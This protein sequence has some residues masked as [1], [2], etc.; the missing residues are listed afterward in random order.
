MHTHR[1]SF[2]SSS[3][4]RRGFL[5]GSV[6][7]GAALLSE[8]AIAQARLEAA[9]AGIRAHDW[10]TLPLHDG[11]T[12]TVGEKELGGDFQL[13][14]GVRGDFEPSRTLE[15]AVFQSAG[16]FNMVGMH[17]VADVPEGTSL[18]V[19]VRGSR[20]GVKWGP[21][22]PVGHVMGARG[23]EELPE[24]AETF[25]DAVEFGRARAMQYRLT[26]GT[27][28]P[29]LSPIVR[30]VTAT[31]IDSLDAPTLEMLDENGPGIPFRVG[32][33]GAPGARLIP[34][35]G[36]TGWG[37]T[38]Y[39]P[40]SPLWWEPYT[41]VYPTQFV[42][43]HHTAWANNPENP[44]ATMRAV[45]YYHCVTLGWG[46]IGYHFLV[47]Q[48]GNIYQGRDGGH[49]TEAGHVSRYNHYNIGIC[50]M[51]QFHP[52]APDVPPGGEPTP[53]ALDTAM[54]MAALEAAWWGLNPLEKG[55]YAK[56]DI[57]CRPQ[58][59]NYRICGHQDWGRNGSCVATLCPGSNVY[60][61][62]PSIRQQA[63]ALIPHIHEFNLMRMLDRDV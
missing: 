43:I 40:G 9:A 53:E 11:S 17:W 27:T 38:D 58:L 42:T 13:R 8:R 28:K 39:G 10:H 31:Q 14:R 61:H 62:L 60:K 3:L 30:R 1:S 19:Q 51:G 44:V 32:N 23:D 63:A 2:R 56:P 50:L 24:G 57:A 21:W 5:K 16:F 4:G 52:G 59:W 45:W 37:P 47:D 25:T 54:R 26:L 48:F 41:G 46:D 20:D 55:I 29:A 6:A 7:L 49:A 35:D 36:S 18:E 33:G 22:S 12:V 15:S 34:R